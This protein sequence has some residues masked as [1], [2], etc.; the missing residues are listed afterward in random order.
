MLIENRRE[1][2]SADTRAKYN[3]PIIS[4]FAHRYTEKESH[5]LGARIDV[6]N[7]SRDG[8]A[9]VPAQRTRVGEGSNRS[10]N[11][12]RAVDTDQDKRAVFQTCSILRSR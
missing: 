5:C 11:L 12:F 8:P 4:E 10:N 6:Q 9:E 2:L 3:N 1:D 7:T